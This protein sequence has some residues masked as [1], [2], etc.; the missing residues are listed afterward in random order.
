MFR[1]PAAGPLPNLLGT[2]VKKGNSGMS[3]KPASEPS[4][5]SSTLD[6]GKKAAKMRI[7]KH[8][9]ARNL[10]AF[11]YI[12]EHPSTS[13]VDFDKVWKGL[14]KAVL[15]T[16]GYQEYDALREYA[17]LCGDDTLDMI[18]DAWGNLGKEEREN[19]YK[20]EAAPKDRKGKAKA[21]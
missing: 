10:Y 15:K 14:D 6:Q 2:L 16:D 18:V 19:Y 7:S 11:M 5:G 9:T 21:K 20:A 12:K 4:A 1:N 3:S 17:L 13:A 8:K